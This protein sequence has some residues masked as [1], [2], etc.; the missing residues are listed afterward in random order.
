MKNS[1]LI[2]LFTIW[3]LFAHAQVF[4]GVV[5]DAK[6]GVPLPYVNVGIVNKGVGTVTDNAGRFKIN[7]SGHAT[8]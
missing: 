6:T 4:D 8:A 2:S 1:I 5:K 7:L 3:A